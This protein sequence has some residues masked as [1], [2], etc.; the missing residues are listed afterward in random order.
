[1]GI[2]SPFIQSHSFSLLNEGG[3]DFSSLATLSKGFFIIEFSHQ[4]L[5]MFCEHNIR[6]LISI[7]KYLIW[8]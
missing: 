4:A 8:Y 1:M 6:N 2:C 5:K 3:T 7:F